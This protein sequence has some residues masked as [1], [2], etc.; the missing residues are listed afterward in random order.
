M[1]ETPVNPEL[2]D[3]LAVEFLES[4]WDVKHLFRLM[5]E[6]RAYRQD[7]H[8]TPEK[9]ERDPG[10]R[11]LSQGPQFRMDA[12]MVQDYALAAG[13]LLV[14]RIGGPSVKPY[15][16]PGFGRRWRCRKSNTKRY[17]QDSGIPCIGAACTP[18]EAGG[19]TGV[20]GHLQCSQPG[21]VVHAAGADQY[22]ASGAGHVE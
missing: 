15:Q 21:G 1:G 14:P 11:L 20:D 18:L 22:A 2:L 9:L 3:W 13:G 12:E 10:N 5:V 4:G 17:Q 16:P 6:S 19:A 7:A 8:V